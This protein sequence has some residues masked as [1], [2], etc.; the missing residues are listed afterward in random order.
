MQPDVRPLA[1]AYAFAGA[2]R[3]QEALPIIATHAATGNAEALFT[4]GDLYWRGF[5]VE[6]D[7]ARALELFRRSSDGG[8]P[9]A[10]RA[11]TNLLA[12]GAT[13][14][15][16]WQAALARLSDEARDDQFRG[17]MLRLISNM[18]LTPAGDPVR[19]AAGERLSEEPH[20]TIFRNGFTTEECDFLRAVA[21]PT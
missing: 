6:R 19:V 9:M 18:N 16:D 13:G 1:D 14:D 20:V 17:W 11:Y 15:R 10:V 8:F 7:H 12:N 5:G 21:E 4:L 3:L 2:G